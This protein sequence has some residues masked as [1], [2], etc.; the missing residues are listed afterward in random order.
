MAVVVNTVVVHM[1]R[2]V[3]HYR[4][5]MPASTVVHVVQVQGKMLA[6]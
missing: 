6:A 4:P 2:A 5:V 3:M 1:H